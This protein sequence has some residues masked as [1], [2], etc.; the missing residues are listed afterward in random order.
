MHAFNSETRTPEA[1]WPKSV[2]AIQSIINNSPSRRLGGRSPITVHTG[3]PSGN[4]LTVAL[5]Q[6]S[7]QDISSIDEVKLLQELKMDELHESLDKM[8]KAVGETLSDSRRKAVERHNN[9]THV[10]PYKPIVGDYVVIARTHGP[11][12]KMST[13]WVGPRR[14]SRILS[15]FTV[16]IE[17][18]LTKATAVVHVCRV[19][20]Y[21]DASV[22]TQVQMQEVA[23]FTDRIWYSVDKLKDV[24]EVS[25]H[26][27]VLVAWKGLT[28]AGDSWEPLTVMFEDVPSKV[29]EFFK[30]RR[31]NPILRRAR[32][33]IG[34]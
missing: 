23:E 16:E 26:F 6:C 27:E 1:D 22:G 31:L 12:T 9:K 13:N 21:A 19:K 3:M 24:R 18:L 30:R 34:L 29:R 14:I 33:S 25:G 7:T 4:P 2:Q 17:H 11:R 15:D 10:V 20:P 28:T 8:H 5:T 32:A